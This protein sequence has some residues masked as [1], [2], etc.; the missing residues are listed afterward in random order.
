MSITNKI[1]CVKITDENARMFF[2]E[3]I[4]PQKID[5]VLEWCEKYE[6]KETAILLSSQDKTYKYI[7]DEYF[8]EDNFKSF[9]KNFLSKYITITSSKEYEEKY[10]L[11][12]FDH[13]YA[14]LFLEKYTEI[15]E[16]INE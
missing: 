15:M 12:S 6:G 2:I 14:N 13:T 3:G 7:I 8:D 10:G 9:I 16:N 4:E 1:C 11:N 5:Y